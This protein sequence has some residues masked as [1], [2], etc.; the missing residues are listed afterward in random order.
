MKQNN[1]IFPLDMAG[2]TYSNTD[3]LMINVNGVVLTEEYDYLLDTSKTPV[4]IHTNA[5]LEAENIL[6]CF[7][8]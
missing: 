6:E 8:Q 3:I 7:E 1:G 2:Y 5:D 4:E